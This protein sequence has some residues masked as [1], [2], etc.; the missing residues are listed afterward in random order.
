MKIVDKEL[1]EA[2]NSLPPQERRAVE[3]AIEGGNS[4]HTRALLSE[5]MRRI[6]RRIKYKARNRSTVR[7]KI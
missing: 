2:I 7:S 3:K 1:I 6:K 5:A 4:T